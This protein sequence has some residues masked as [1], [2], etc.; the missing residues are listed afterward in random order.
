M[1]VVVTQITVSPI[2]A[3]MEAR[4]VTWWMTTAVRV[5]LASLARIVRHDLP[6]T[7]CVSLLIHA[8]VTACVCWTTPPA[9]CA[10]SASLA[11]PQVCCHHRCVM[12]SS[13]CDCLFS[14]GGY[15][16]PCPLDPPLS[17][18]CLSTPRQPSY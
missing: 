2:P 18:P 12:F 10:V 17:P 14:L 13:S 11:T 7:V 1:Y 16:T 3:C 9:Q 6:L 5:P 4:A 15:L 8:A